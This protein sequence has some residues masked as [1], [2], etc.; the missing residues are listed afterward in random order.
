LGACAAWLALPPQV[1]P[2]YA[3]VLRRIARGEPVR[4]CHEASKKWSRKFNVPHGKT[5]AVRASR[6]DRL[7]YI[8]DATRVE[9]LGFGDRSDKSLY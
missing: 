5:V 7:F 1:R 2:R 6:R 8:R 9:V 4:L 3:K